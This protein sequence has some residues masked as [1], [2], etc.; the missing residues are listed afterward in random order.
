MAKEGK[1][2]GGKLV[3]ALDHPIVF[4]FFV[5]CAVAGMMTL[6]T[7]G[8]KSIGATGPAAVFQHP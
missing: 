5:T 2:G 6:L 4:I 7:W 3:Q 8:F 1:E